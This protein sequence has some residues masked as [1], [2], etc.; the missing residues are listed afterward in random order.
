MSRTIFLYIL[1]YTI[2]YR[3]ITIL[4]MDIYMSTNCLYIYK[5]Q[6]INTIMEK[7][8]PGSNEEIKL[9]SNSVIKRST[10]SNIF[11]DLINIHVNKDDH[12]LVLINLIIQ[13]FMK[14]RMHQVITNLN[15]EIYI[16]NAYIIYL[17]EG[18]SN[19]EY[20]YYKYIA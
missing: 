7:K 11:P 18:C 5:L 16:Y 4:F 15:E 12:K 13:K 1:V 17:V 14:I 9:I 2:L 10:D 8:I 3:Y 6:K 19:I 20:A